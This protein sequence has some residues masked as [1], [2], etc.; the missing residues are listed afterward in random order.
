MSLRANAAA[1]DAQSVPLVEDQ[2]AAS[3]RVATEEGKRLAVP[4]SRTVASYL[5]QFWPRRNDSNSSVDSGLSLE[6]E[7]RE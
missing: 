7:S 2:I 6:P 4:S 5:H 3:A 1:A